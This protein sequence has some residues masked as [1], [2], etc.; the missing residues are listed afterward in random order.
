MIKFVL[1]HFYI[2]TGILSLDRELLE[3]KGLY[4]RFIFS[5]WCSDSLISLLLRWIH[6]LGWNWS[7]WRR[8]AWAWIRALS[9]RIGTTINW[10]WC[11]PIHHGSVRIPAWTVRWRSLHRVPWWGNSCLLRQGSTWHHL[12]LIWIRTHVARL[13]LHWHWLLLTTLIRHHVLIN[14]LRGGL[15]VRHLLLST[16]VVLIGLLINNLFLR[17]FQLCRRVESCS[18]LLLLSPINIIAH[19]IGSTYSPIWKEQK[20]YLA[21]SSQKTS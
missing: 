8:R 12:S 11:L 10:A 17:L 5:C 6:I 19:G 9:W 3:V 13:S 4:S 7:Y 1:L 15:D 2:Q 14:V 20:E 16:C 18:G 21:D